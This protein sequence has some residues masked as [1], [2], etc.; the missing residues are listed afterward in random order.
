MFGAANRAF[1][2]LREL[3]RMGLFDFLKPGKPE[4]KAA[5]QR[6]PPSPNLG[7][8]TDP[9]ADSELAI[10]VARQRQAIIARSSY[11][12]R[13]IIGRQYLVHRVLG[14]GGFGLVYLVST[15]DDGTIYAVKTF[16][17]E[18]MF[19]EDVKR[20]FEKEA[21]VWVHL[22]W[23]PFIVQA[24]EVRL[25]DGRMF[26]AMDF[27]AP[28]ENG[29]VSLHDHIAF[30]GR[31]LG[32]TT[33]GNWAIQFCHG[34]EHALS[35]GIKAHRDIKPMNLLIGGGI[36]RI[37]DFGLV[38]ALARSPKLPAHLT[39]DPGLTIFQSD[40]QSCAGTPGYI[41]PELMRSEGSGIHSDVFAFGVSLWQMTAG[42]AELPYKV[43]YRGDLNTFAREIYESQMRGAIRQF[44]SI[45][46]PII[47]KCL[48]PDPTM[49]YASYA[50]L[51]SSVKEVMKRAGLVPT[52]F[53]V[54][55]DRKSAAE[56]VN[57]G[58]SLKAL[59]K[60][61]D[62][63]KCFDQ[64]LVLEPR[65][66][67]ALVNKGNALSSLGRAAESLA[68]YEAAIHSDPR[69]ESAWLNR[70]IHFQRERNH[71]RAIRSFDKLLKLNPE[72]ALALSLK[73]ESCMACGQAQDAL[74]CAKAAVELRAYDAGFWNNYGQRF[75]ECNQADQALR[76]YERAIGLD[77]SYLPARINKAK[78]LAVSGHANESA[79]CF[80][81]LEG[82]YSENAAALNQI[83][84][85][86]CSIDEQSAA[87]P[88]F[89]RALALKPE[90]PAVIM[91][92]K[93]TA[94]LELDDQAQAIAWFNRALQVDSRYLPAYI[95][96][97]KAYHQL[98]KLQETVD[99]YG[100]A[101]AVDKSSQECWFGRGAA[102]L[103]MGQ[104]ARA[105]SDLDQA[106]ALNPLD[107]RVIYNKG[108]AYIQLD[109]AIGALE[110]FASAVSINPKYL[111]A[112]YARAQVEQALG[113][114][115]AALKSCRAYLEVSIAEAPARTAILRM[116]K[117]LS[118]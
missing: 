88:I 103:E 63:I 50:D 58:C 20:N 62:A 53:I 112:W 96:I 115:D 77:Q 101:I 90:E 40:G 1:S 82:V 36:L 118:S 18:F 51:R 49:R 38:V 34:M 13:D 79:R 14:R 3:E 98:G 71:Q 59:G 70:A 5:P 89:D 19:D 85:A 31:R 22:G 86:L 37:S 57:R 87:I 26:V 60:I 93:G 27:V 29:L 91:S 30:H 104:A 35:R 10:G 24:H 107:E 25:L 55:K 97:A 52:D 23:N 12:P 64:A 94:L 73:G 54:N 21:Q 43:K 28:D 105:M 33:I 116:L 74:N 100:K 99:W 108:A 83:A 109:D 106:H 9:R 15:V 81:T 46:W 7:G 66:A 39:R 76:C 68:M 48:H 84:V 117:E 95:Q 113:Q 41:S 75:S 42:T 47:Q 16:L 44:Q 11:H 67:I 111:N 65:H 8:E 114:R 80:E 2:L 4:L 110:C 69:C 72:H 6:Q 102:L 56:L 32:D 92:N 61:E 78:Q 45:Y 17:D